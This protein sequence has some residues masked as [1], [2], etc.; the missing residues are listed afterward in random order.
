MGTVVLATTIVIL[1]VTDGSSGDGS[2]SGDGG[3]VDDGSDD[4][5]HD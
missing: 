5:D 3:Y 4:R 1:L 2:G